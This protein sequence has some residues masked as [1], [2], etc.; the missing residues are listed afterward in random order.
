MLHREPKV[1][2]VLAFSSRPSP[3]LLD[4]IE[5]PED[6]SEFTDLFCTPSDT[7]S[8]SETPGSSPSFTSRAG[9]RRRQAVTLAR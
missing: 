5:H 3:L 8:P 4:A 2:V 7:P 1:T 6:L 9:A